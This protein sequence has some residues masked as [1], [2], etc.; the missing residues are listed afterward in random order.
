[1][2]QL[3]AKDLVVA[4]SNLGRW[5]DHDERGTLNFLTP[6]R[7]VAAAGLVKVGLVVPL[8]APMRTVGPGATPGVKHRMLA[9]EDSRQLGASDEIAIASHGFAVTHLDALGHVFLNGRTWGGRLAD[10]VVSSEGMSFASVFP[11]REGI[12]TR[13]VLLDVAA[14]RGV[15]YLEAGTFVTAQDLDAAEHLA[16]VEVGEGDAIVVHTGLERRLALGQSDDPALRTGLDADC[17]P[18]IHRRRIG[19]YA[20]DCIERLPSRV[21]D[22][23]LPLHSIGM[24]N[25]GLVM[26]DNPQVSQLVD[27]VRTTGTSE[28]LLVCVPLPIDGATGSPVAPIAVF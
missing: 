20:G 16:G 17:L 6:E 1:M 21:R 26:L 27:A 19:V 15:S 22:L 18:W 10:D 25:M 13:G 8:A 5:G 3:S 7:R 24:A 11:L 28:F 4:C 14:A 9:N 2:S 23:P 12:F